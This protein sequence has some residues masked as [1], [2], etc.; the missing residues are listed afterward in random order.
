[1]LNLGALFLKRSRDVQT[2]S[3]GNISVAQHRKET[4]AEH[5]ESYTE[6]VIEPSSLEFQSNSVL[7]ESEF[8]YRKGFVDKLFDKFRKFT[9]QY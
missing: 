9:E 1:M 2:F 4:R 3:I 7:G 8:V 5:C 6:E